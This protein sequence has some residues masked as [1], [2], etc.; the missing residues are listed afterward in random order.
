MSGFGL[1]TA[2]VFCIKIGVRRRI[3]RGARLCCP[4]IFLT[5]H[6]SSVFGRKAFHHYC[7]VDQ[8]PAPQVGTVRCSKAP[9]ERKPHG[10]VQHQAQAQRRRV[11]GFR[12]RGACVFELMS[13]VLVLTRSV[14]HVRKRE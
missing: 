1:G 3:V 13:T 9:A 4:V 11:E 2:A 10:S 14:E 8:D 12:P 5:A 6:T 7:D